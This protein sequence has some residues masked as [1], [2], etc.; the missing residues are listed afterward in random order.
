MR[1]YVLED[2]QSE[3]MLIYNNKEPAFASSHIYTVICVDILMR[4]DANSIFDCA[5]VLSCTPSN[6]IIEVCE[7]VS[8]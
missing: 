2:V 8:K 1:R 4:C 7:Q 3:G 5:G 6:Q